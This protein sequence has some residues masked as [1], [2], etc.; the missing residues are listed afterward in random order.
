MKK[1]MERLNKKGFTLAELLIVVAIIAVLV[2]ISIPVFNS[3]L[4]K[5][6]EST[7][8]ANVRAAY[9]E[10]MAAAISGDGTSATTNSTAYTLTGSGSE[11]S[12]VYTAKVPLKQKQANWQSASV[13]SIGGVALSG[14]TDVGANK[15]I[16]ITYTQA[17]TNPVAMSVE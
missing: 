1:M 10:L 6:R 12:F 11:G 13:D 9:A 4:E 3:Q 5:A 2:A 8:M 14:L 17:N 15:S 7:D 16:V